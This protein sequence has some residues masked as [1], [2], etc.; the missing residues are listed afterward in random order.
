MMI[1][2]NGFNFFF[3]MIAF[4]LSLILTWINIS[5][6]L[7]FIIMKEF[8]KPVVKYYGSSSLVIRINHVSLK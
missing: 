2:M 8:G 5:D 3:S 6:N 4:I 1:R 7:N